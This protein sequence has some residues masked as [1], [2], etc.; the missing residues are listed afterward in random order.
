MATP[1]FEVLAM[2]QLIKSTS[3]ARKFTKRESNLKEVRSILAAKHEVLESRAG[4]TLVRVTY[5]Q[6]MPNDYKYA[7]INGS[8]AELLYEVYAKH[9]EFSIGNVSL[10]PIQQVLLW[11]SKDAFVETAGLAKLVFWDYLFQHHTTICTDT[12]QTEYGRRFW[13]YRIV[14]AF[15]RGFHVYAVDTEAGVACLMTPDNAQDTAAHIYGTAKRFMQYV[16]LIS[17]CPL[18]IPLGLSFD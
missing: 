16:I 8:K 7:L 6:F 11:R 12:C 13:G 9:Y 3:F 14:E 15:E 2:P 10:S 4:L 1:K 5:D 18:N 17:A